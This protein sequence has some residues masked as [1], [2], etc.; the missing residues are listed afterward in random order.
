LRCERECSDRAS[1]DAKGLSTTKVTGHGFSQDR[2]DDRCSVGAGINA[3]L[4][5][6]TPLCVGYHGLSFRNPLSGAGGTGDDTRGIAAVLAHNGH[7]HG[8]FSP[9]F[10]LDA[11]ERRGTRSL[12]KE[13]T[14]RF[15][16]LATRAEVR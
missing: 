2:M 4:T 6:N 15:T 8:N 11:R 9:F 10:H 13:A 14:D 5:T 16:G 12:M 1:I 7:P 3:G